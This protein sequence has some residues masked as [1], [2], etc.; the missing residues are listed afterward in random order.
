MS[1]M[2]LI[3]PGQGSHSMGMDEPY[4]DSE[5]FERGLDLLG[6]DP[7]PRLE[8]GTRWQQPAVFLCSVCAWA[9]AG[10]PTA[11]A[12]AG[13]SLGEY[14]AL[15]A[16]GALEF[17]AAMRLVELRAKVMAAAAEE[18]PGG[19][20]A[21]LGGDPDAVRRLADELGLVVANDNAPGQLVLSGDTEAV[22]QVVSRAGEEAGARSRTLSVSGPFHS[23][24]MEPAVP[25]LRDA[26]A[27]ADFRE[28]DFPVYSCAT[29]APF[30][31]PAEE[32]ALNVIRPV[33]WRETV[34]A[35]RAAGVENFIELGP[36]QVLTGLLRRIL[37]EQQVAGG[38]S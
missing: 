23:E 9:E 37:P 18:S 14:A 1:T 17:D 25:P 22:E 7:F 31:D 32:L 16:A 6:E 21:M 15:V 8:E 28:P 38:V 13:H 12:A 3:F 27:E 24:A 11:A 5:L 34:L 33:R 2:A 19:M 4:R 35:M 26:L 10:R 29:A 30:E 20:V 36:G